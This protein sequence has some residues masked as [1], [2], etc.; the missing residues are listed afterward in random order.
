MVLLTISHGQQVGW[1]LVRSLPVLM[2]VG[3]DSPIWLY[4]LSIDWAMGQPAVPINWGHNN[5]TGMWKLS[6]NL[7]F[8]KTMYFC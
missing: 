4:F 5:V 6:G 8:Q 7:C 1:A 2:P 3:L